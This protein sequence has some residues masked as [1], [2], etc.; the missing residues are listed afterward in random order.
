MKDDLRIIDSDMHTRNP[1]ILDRYM[2]VRFKDR[3]SRRVRVPTCGDL[4]SMKS[5]HLSVR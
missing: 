1:W 3:A 4:R 5:C 2:E